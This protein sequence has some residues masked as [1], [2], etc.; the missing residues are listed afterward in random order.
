MDDFGKF[1]QHPIAYDKSV[2]N[3]GLGFVFVP[4]RFSETL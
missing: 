1:Q 2:I 4:C 3:V